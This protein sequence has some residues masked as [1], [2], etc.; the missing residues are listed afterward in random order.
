MINV[1]FLATNV[2]AIKDNLVMGALITTLP[3]RKC[4]IEIFQLKLHWHRYPELY[5]YLD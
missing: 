5:R 2:G 4:Q 1:T 3:G